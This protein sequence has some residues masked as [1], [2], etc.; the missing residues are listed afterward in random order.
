MVSTPRR[1]RPVLSA[2][3]QGEIMPVKVATHVAGTLAFV[4]GAIVQIGMSFDVAGH[5]HTPIEIYG[6][7]ASLI[8]PDPNR[9]GGELALRRPL[10][11]A[12]WEPVAVEKPYAEG[13]FR[14][15]GAA[16]MAQAILEN[17]PHRASGDLALHVLEVMLAFDRASAEDRA[18]AIETRPDRPAP[19]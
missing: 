19:L 18:V 9:F 2:P 5:R 15:L 17:R 10:R 4:S 6:T 7:N 14:S 13:N 12:P 11:D 8:V 3:K 1:E 16:D